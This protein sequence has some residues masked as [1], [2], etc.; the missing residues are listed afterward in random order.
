MADELADA[1]RIAAAQRAANGADYIEVVSS[2]DNFTVQV[3]V[4]IHADPAARAAFLRDAR[5]AANAERQTAATTRRRNESGIVGR[6][7]EFIASVNRGTT[8]LFDVATA[9][10]QGAYNLGAWGARELG[11]DAPGIPTLRSTVPERGEF[12]NDDALTRIIAGTGELASMAVPAGVAVRGITNG[13][14]TASKYGQTTFNRVLDV[15]GRTTPQQ[16]L[17]YGLISGAGGEMLAEGGAALGVE[18]QLG[19]DALRL[20]G[21]VVSPIAWTQAANKLGN[22]IK[23]VIA[24][25]APSA[26]RIRGASRAA[27]AMLDSGGWKADGPSVDRL[28]NMVNEFGIDMSIHPATGTGTVAGKMKQLLAAADESLVSWSF[29]DDARTTLHT[30]GKGTDTQATHAKSLANKLDELILEMTPDK[31]AGEKPWGELLQNARS[32]WRRQKTAQVVEDVRHNAEVSAMNN[33]NKDAFINAFKNGLRNLLKKGKKNNQGNFLNKE[34]R[35]LIASAINGTKLSQTLEN[36]GSAIGFQSDDL[37]R[38]VALSGVAGA[39]AGFGAAG[40]G[41]SATGALYGGLAIMGSTALGSTLKNVSR[42]LF[43]S[44][45]KLQE[46]LLKA[47]QNAEQIARSYLTNS[48]SRDPRELA[49]LLVNQGADPAELRNITTRSEFLNEATSLAI[50]FSQA[51]MRE[52][53]A[54]ENPAQQ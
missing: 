48:K 40:A 42:R 18:N 39:A 31:I 9:P 50:I 24:S 32:L 28:R 27:Y 7:M 45:S 49:I 10:L 25:A 1:E 19:Q 4:E 47:G 38:N 34:E 36:I 2:R 33:P 52:E 14:S 23:E 16:D 26:E 6:G 22:S 41:G 15:I 20:A 30:I 13:L 54:Q 3:P 35:K 5:A 17:G 11:F 43:I 21:Q 8:Q 37:I 29:L 44:N 53:A 51:L 12:A 46:G